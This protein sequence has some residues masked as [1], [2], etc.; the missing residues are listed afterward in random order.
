MYIVGKVCINVFFRFALFS[1]NSGKV[2]DMVLLWFLTHTNTKP[3]LLWHHFKVWL[4]GIDTSC[5]GL[6][7]HSN[8]LFPVHYL[9]TFFVLSVFSQMFPVCYFGLSTST[10]PSLQKHPHLPRTFHNSS[11]TSKRKTFTDKDKMIRWWEDQWNINVSACLCNKLYTLGTIVWSEKTRGA[12]SVC[13]TFLSAYYQLRKFDLEDSTCIGRDAA[14]EHYAWLSHFISEKNNNTP[15]LI[16][17]TG[18]AS[19]SNT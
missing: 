2:P 5:S 19:V 11:V 18:R 14:G 7:F 9:S 1:I 3:H 13:P 12:Q 4:R 10:R 6:Y 16:T 15:S 17:A 8:A